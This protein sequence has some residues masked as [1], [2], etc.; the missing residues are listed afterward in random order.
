MLDER[1]RAG[2]TGAIAP[3][4]CVACQ[5]PIT[6]GDS[7]IVR[8]GSGVS[9]DGTKHDLPTGSKATVVEVSSWEGEG[10]VFLVQPPSGKP[11]YVA[12]FQIAPPRQT[13]PDNRG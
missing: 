11:V 10:T 9:D 3:A 13:R 8:K 6:S 1:I 7:V 12:R 2:W 5:E 4:K